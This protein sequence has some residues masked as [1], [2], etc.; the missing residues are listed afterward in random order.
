MP[1]HAS[2]MAPA[3]RRHFAVVM[4]VVIALAV[5]GVS[6]WQKT[7][8]AIGMRES[9][10]IA[11][12]VAPNYETVSPK[13]A[14]AVPPDTISR[15][16]SLVQLHAEFR[17]SQ[18]CLNERVIVRANLGNGSGTMPPHIPGCDEMR[19]ALRRLYEATRAAA[20]AGDLDAQMCYLMQIA[21][22]RDTGFM[23]SDVEIA[24]YQSLAP[25]YV[26]AAFKRGDWRVVDLL[27]FHVVDSPGLFVQ[28]EQWKDPLR[29]YKAHHLLLLGAG[30][31]DPQDPD[32]WL[33]PVPIPES[34]LSAQEIR[35][36]DAWA[37]EM[38]DKYF[39]S[40]P[41]LM[42]EPRVCTDQDATG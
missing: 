25:Q 3:S 15:Q 36:S 21:G 14:S 13:P 35:D 24:E 39:I 29:E 19:I 31:V 10:S 5:Y 38:Y 9:R 16:K 23:L 40:Q 41:K 27:G 11:S 30:D 22:E 42:R 26:D 32:Y 33:P 20:Q 7:E 2:L 28:L 37:H 4:L 18:R 8:P 34:T 12:G 6:R 17:E 1:W